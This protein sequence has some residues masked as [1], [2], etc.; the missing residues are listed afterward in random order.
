MTDPEL[1]N[2][3]FEAHRPH[4]GAIA[5]RMLGSSHEADDAVQ[6]T[7]L[8]LRRADAQRIDDL[9]RWLAAARAAGD[10]GELPPLPD[11]LP[12]DRDRFD[13]G[14]F[15]RVLLLFSSNKRSLLQHLSYY[16]C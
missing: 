6:E 15:V 3:R 2:Q 13:A 4:L 8:R 11:D 16:R 7:W 9:G 5:V 14:P 10:R 12:A 1:L